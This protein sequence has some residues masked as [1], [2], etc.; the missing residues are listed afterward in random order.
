NKIDVALSILQGITSCIPECDEYQAIW[1]YTKEII[2]LIL[3]NGFV[4]HSLDSISTF[5]SILEIMSVMSEIFT[6]SGFLDTRINNEIKDL[7]VYLD[8]M[9]Y[10]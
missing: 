8:K 3:F 6:N 4:Y 7:Q 9:L 1:E 2:L 10:I 5:D